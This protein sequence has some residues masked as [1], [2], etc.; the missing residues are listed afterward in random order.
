VVPVFNSE[1]G[2]TAAAI[3]LVSALVKLKNNFTHPTLNFFVRCPDAAAGN[4]RCRF[5]LRNLT[6]IS[7]EG[8]LALPY[9]ARVCENQVKIRDFFNCE[10]WLSGFKNSK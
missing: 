9:I 10:K 5:F 6:V 8:L 1:I 2:F 3:F 4:A 7:P